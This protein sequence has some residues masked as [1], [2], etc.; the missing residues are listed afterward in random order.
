MRAVEPPIP[1]LLVATD[2]KKNADGTLIDRKALDEKRTKAEEKQKA[3]DQ[4]V[5]AKDPNF[6]KT[7]KAPL[8]PTDNPLGYTPPCAL[9]P[10]PGG[11]PLEEDPL[12]DTLQLRLTT[13]SGEDDAFSGSCLQSFDRQTR[14]PFASLL[15]G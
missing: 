7:D 3:L 15:T 13:P 5:L 4:A 12:S 10:P 6:G 9:D 1:N 2:N 11:K 14:R 8:I